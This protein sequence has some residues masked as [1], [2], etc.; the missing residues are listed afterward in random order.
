MSRLHEL[1][2][3]LAKPDWNE[4]L[5]NLYL[6]SVYCL[7]DPKEVAFTSSLGAVLSLVSS[8][9][10]TKEEIDRMLPPGCAHMYVDIEDRYDA[11]MKPYFKPGA[12]FIQ[13]YLDRGKRVFVHCVAGKSRS[14]TM[15]AYYVMMLPAWRH[16]SLE[17]VLL[18][19]KGKRCIIRPNEGF[20]LQL[21]WAEERR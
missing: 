17:D 15:M 4:I 18:F 14:A 19:I 12:A 8:K 3:L 16:K 11:N 7:D 9:D 21:M 2:E 10:F 20:L 6:G 5:P 13:L 1:S